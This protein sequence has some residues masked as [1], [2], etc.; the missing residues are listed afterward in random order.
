MNPAALKIRRIRPGDNEELAALIREVLPD[1]QVPCEGTALGDPELDRMFETYD[2][3]GAAYWVITDGDQIWGGGGI[4]PLAGGEPGF[5]ELQKMYFRESMRGKGFGRTLL[6]K[7]LARARSMG[8]TDCYLE[9]MPHMEA[10]QSLYRSYGFEY[11]DK[12]LGS[13]GHEACQVWM[14]KTF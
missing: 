13:T 4:A 9:T 7:A 1:F 2:R 10:A 14:R 6:N 8:Y 12:P 5:C 11:L 3:P